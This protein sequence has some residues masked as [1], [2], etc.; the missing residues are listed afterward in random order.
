VADAPHI[1]PFAFCI[2]TTIAVRC[3]TANRIHDASAG[4]AR[5]RGSLGQVLR[6]I[7][8]RVRCHF[9]ARQQMAA[10]MRFIFA[11]FSFLALTD[12]TL[13]NPFDDCVLGNMQGATSDVAAKS[14]KVAC[15]RKTSI[16]I[17]EDDLQNLKGTAEY[18]TLS[19]NFG[20]GFLITLTNNMEFIVT[21]VTLKIS[22]NKGPIRYVRTDDF[23]LPTDAIVAALP[24]DPTQ[25]MRINPFTTRSFA[26][27]TND[28]IDPKKPSFQLGNCK[29]EGHPD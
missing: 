15:L 12:Q 8:R 2:A 28:E 3:E 13:G 29:R 16:A 10:L 19:R 17:S 18:G 20:P 23:N 22:V 21:E 4:T 5:A 25:S 7:T 14:I 1:I 26:I 9:S 24:P 6:G 27:G 11:T